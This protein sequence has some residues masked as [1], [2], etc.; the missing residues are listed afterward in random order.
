[1][2]PNDEIPLFT[3][4]L[5]EAAENFF[6]ARRDVDA[7][8]EMVGRYAEK[9]KLQQQQVEARAALINY[10]LL[11]GAASKRFFSHLEIDPAP[12]AG[13]APSV[14][15]WYGPLPFA[16][17]AKGRY[18]KVIGQVY[19][20]LAHA[21]HVYM[22]GRPK[23]RKKDETSVHYTLL[24]DMVDLINK[25][26]KR[27]NDSLS[28][29]QSLQFARDFSGQAE[30]SSTG[31]PDCRYVHCLEEKLC[32]QTLDIRG[33]HLAVYPDLPPLTVVESRIRAF[34]QSLF[35][36]HRRQIAHILAVLGKKPGPG[37][38]PPAS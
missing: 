13:V 14:A 37:H 26:I 10:L 2:P 9:L 11:D 8:I 15:V 28:P 38:V 23:V 16:L 17:T 6:G 12:F 20:E 31:V 4:V 30:V 22:H 3:E 35:P 1:M 24:A 33:F 21:C 27:V 7:M 25:E 19:E 36:D 34:T 32:F 5:S 29:C 18:I